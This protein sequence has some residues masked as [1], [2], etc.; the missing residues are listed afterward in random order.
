[1]QVNHMGRRSVRSALAVGGALIA[2]AALAGAA[3]AAGPFD[4]TYTGPAVLLSGNNG[5]V[6]KTF[7]TSMTVTD[8]HLT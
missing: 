7:S 4:G 2:A 8:G 5:T 3:R 6:C 1:M